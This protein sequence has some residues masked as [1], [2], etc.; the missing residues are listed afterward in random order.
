MLQGCFVQTQM[1][2][3]RKRWKVTDKERSEW[4]KKD[5]EGERKKRI[6]KEK[7]W[8]GVEGRDR[9]RKR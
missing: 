2:E 1:Q 9:K 8:E 5:M 3:E 6:L 7:R 4:K